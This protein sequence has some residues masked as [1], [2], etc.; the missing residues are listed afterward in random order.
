MPFE[1]ISEFIG[2]VATCWGE[3][4]LLVYTDISVR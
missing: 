1:S 4:G 2:V 3:L